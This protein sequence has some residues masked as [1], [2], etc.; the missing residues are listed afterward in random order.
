MR[1]WR[2]PKHERGCRWSGSNAGAIYDELC[3]TGCARWGLVAAGGRMETSGQDPVG[4]ATPE[5]SSSS[6][7]SLVEARSGG[8]NTGVTAE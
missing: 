6:V 2:K 8:S 7:V 1:V 5:E 4:S 3:E